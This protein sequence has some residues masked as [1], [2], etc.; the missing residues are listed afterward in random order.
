MKNKS[1]LGIRFIW[2][3]LALVAIAIVFFCI[4][5]SGNSL[6]ANRIGAIVFSFIL[7]FGVDILRLIRINIPAD[8]EFAYLIFLLFAQYLGIDFNAYKWLPHYDK[9]IHAVSGVLTII[10]GY[11]LAAAL[12]I[13]TSHKFLDARALFALYFAITIAFAWECVEFF[14][15]KVFGMNMQTLISKGLDDTMLDMIFA[16]IGAILAVLAYKYVFPK[17]KRKK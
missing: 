11:I 13:P 15:D 4:A 17:L 10:A 16:T 14:A 8:L 1:L 7:P 2:L 12:K 6:A 5:L 9:I 3:K